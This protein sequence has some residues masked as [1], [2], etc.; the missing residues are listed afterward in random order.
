MTEQDQKVFCPSCGEL[1]EPLIMLT[2]GEELV[3]CS[4][5]GIDLTKRTYARKAVDRIL[6]ADDSNVMRKYVAGL[7]VD[8][9]AAKD[10]VESED[11]RVFL[12]QL[13][14]LL[15]NKA[16]VD[17]IIL[18]VNMPVVNGIDAARTLRAIETGL[19][20]ERR[21]PILFLTIVRCDE[22]F[23]KMMSLTKPA[24]YLN[25]GAS[26]DKEE[27]GKRLLD[28]IDRIRGLSGVSA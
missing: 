3:H 5:C 2:G 11:G 21:I 18:D 8:R 17:L 27:F 14:G 23:K 1:V 9:G 13:S 16:A 6:I 25:K 10:V 7:L 28:V 4:V 20:V 15:K 26:Q 12:S 22:N 24:A 19:K